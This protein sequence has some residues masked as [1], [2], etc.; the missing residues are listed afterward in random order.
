MACE[1]SLLSYPG[2]QPSPGGPGSSAH[3]WPFASPP[4]KFSLRSVEEGPSFPAA[5]SVLREMERRG[6]VRSAATAHSHLVRQRRGCL[7]SLS[8]PTCPLCPSSLGGQ[9][10]LGL[11]LTDVSPA[12]HAPASLP[13]WQIPA[14]WS[15]PA[16]MAACGVKAFCRGPWPAPRCL[17]PGHRARHSEGVGM[18]LLNE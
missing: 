15:I 18:R 2:H 4:P 16:Q 13:R 8:S 12:W 1:P 17:G 6:S 3:Q 9:G 14:R 7:A 11:A 5:G 10:L